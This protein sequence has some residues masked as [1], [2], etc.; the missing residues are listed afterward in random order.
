MKWNAQVSFPEKIKSKKCSL[1]AQ[2]R[3]NLSGELTRCRLWSSVSIRQTHH[4]QPFRYCNFFI[5]ILCFGTDLDPKCKDHPA[6]SIDLHTMFLSSSHLSRLKLT[7]GC[8]F[9]TPFA[10]VFDFNAWL[11]IQFSQLGWI[12]TGVMPQ[13]CNACYNQKPLLISH[14]VVTFTRR[15]ILNCCHGHTECLGRRTHMCSRWGNH[16]TQTFSLQ[17]TKT[18]VSLRPPPLNFGITLSYKQVIIRFLCAMAII[19]YFSLL[20]LY[21]TN[22]QQQDYNKCWLYDRVLVFGAWGP[23]FKSKLSQCSVLYLL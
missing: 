7:T 20:F 11:S 12:S 23:G 2:R 19:R 1:S 16:H 18:T 21:I 14:L 13:I 6:W 10:N 15:S 17:Q 22:L 9:P 5:K 3:K 8:K 4:V